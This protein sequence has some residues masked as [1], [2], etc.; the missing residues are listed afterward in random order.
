MNALEKS[1]IIVLIST[2][3]ITFNSFAQ[4]LKNKTGVTSVSM[5]ATAYQPFGKDFV[6]SS[7]IMP[8][9]T[10]FSTP[11]FEVKTG[12]LA[13]RTYAPFLNKINSENRNSIKTDFTDVYLINSATYK[14]NPKIQLN[15]S[16]VTSLYNEFDKN[17]FNKPNNFQIK[18]ASLGFEYNITEKLKIQADFRYNNYNSSDYFNP[19]SPSYPMYYGSPF[20]N[21]WR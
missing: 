11:K 19:Y 3:F 10:T 5:G 6:Y 9:F 4:P 16:L 14:L 12:I 17:E 18:S 7:Y 20:M 15:G 2:M 13:S 21:A 1:L 8:T